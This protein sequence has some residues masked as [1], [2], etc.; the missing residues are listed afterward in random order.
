MTL[1]S[2]FT[3]SAVFGDCSILLL[4][5][6]SCFLYHAHLIEEYQITFANFLQECKSRSSLQ[7]YGMLAVFFVPS[8]L[9][10]VL[11]TNLRYIVSGKGFLE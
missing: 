5:S 2:G 7:Y 1:L 11:I 10:V 3:L 6:W 8:S 4:S 9:L